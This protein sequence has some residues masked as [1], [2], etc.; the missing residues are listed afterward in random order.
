[1]PVKARESAKSACVELTGEREKW[2]VGRKALGFTLEWIV[3]AS[4]GPIFIK[5]SL[6]GLTVQKNYV[7]SASFSIVVKL[8]RD[9]V[10]LSSPVYNGAN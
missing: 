1:M 9:S 3:D 7:F 5:Y 8:C 4:F 10:P 2:Y 6:N